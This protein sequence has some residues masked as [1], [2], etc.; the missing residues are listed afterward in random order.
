M[1]LFLNVRRFIDLTRTT[2]T[3]YF[4]FI[5]G[6]EV[7][8]LD[9]RA[10]LP[11]GT[12]ESSARLV[13]SAVFIV[14]ATLLTRLRMQRL[15]RNPKGDRLNRLTLRSTALTLGKHLLSSQKILTK[16]TTTQQCCNTAIAA[17]IFSSYGCP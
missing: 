9:I 7:I 12:C 3:T 8:G 4:F 14:R 2:S 17:V 11:C 16:S 10:N 1:I 13:F 6:H 5:S 15:E